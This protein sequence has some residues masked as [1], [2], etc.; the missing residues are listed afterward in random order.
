MKLS[1]NGW[2]SAGVPSAGPGTDYKFALNETDLLPDPRSAWQPHGVHGPSRLFDHS[3]FQWTDTHWQSRPLASSV[4]YELH[5]GTFTPEGTF[6]SAIGRLPH[7]QHLGV[8]H[9]ELMPVCEFSGNWGWGYDGVDLYAPHTPYGGPAGLKRLVD[10]CHAAGIG[11]ILD[12]VY[13]HLGP[14]GNY[15]SRFGPYLTPRYMTP[16][17]NAVNLDGPGCVE[18]RR[19]FL[20]NA[21]MW[22]R[23]YHIDGLRL[24]AVHALIDNGA[25]HFLEELSQEVESL[26]IRTGRHLFLIAESDKN[27]PRIVHSREVGGYGI[28][29]QW[30]DDFHHA[31]H[32]VLTGERNGYYEDFGSIGQLAKALK[33]TFV[34]D[35]EYSPHRKRP[36]GRPPGGVPRHR[37]LG[38]IQNHDQIGNRAVGERFGHLVSA[39]KLKIAL[40]LVFASPFTPMLFQGEEWAASTPFQYFTDHEDPELAEAVSKGRRNEFVAFGWSP[41]GVPDPQERATFCRSKLKWEERH[42]PSHQEVLDWT[43]RLILLRRAS[44]FLSDPDGPSLNVFFDEQRRWLTMHRGP[45]TVLCNFAAQEQPLEFQ[46]LDET[47]VLLSSDAEAS[48]IEQGVMRMPAESFVITGPLEN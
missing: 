12:V 20:D 29:A 17:G 22:L 33:H 15:L 36:H 43:R 48:V 24:D 41:E 7:L 35:G 34:Y 28:D 8:T 38:Y 30:N 23:D 47:A 45:V 31:I 46:D 14:S 16:W 6:D 25:I 4:I 1:A 2:W 10:A 37:F 42:E 44:R 18:V 19:F 3:E 40:G 39:G 27:D 11:V 5:I 9:V 26:G 21:L 32:C 13:N